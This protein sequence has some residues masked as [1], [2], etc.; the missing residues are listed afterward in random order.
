MELVVVPGVGMIGTTVVAGG[1]SLAEVVGLNLSIVA[2]QPFPIDLV[3]VI[4]LQHSAADDASSR[5]RLDGV[6]HLAKHDIPARLDQ[7]PI[8]FLGDCE[9]GTVGAI[10]CDGSRGSE[11]GG[12]TGGKV[13]LLVGLS[14]GSVCRASYIE[15]EL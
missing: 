5:S 2:T 1:V 12:C 14:E 7:G 3:Q 11:L 10:V 15:S 8:A 6:F 4:G 9:C 13:E